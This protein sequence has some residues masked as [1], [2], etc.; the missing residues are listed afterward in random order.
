MTFQLDLVARWFP[1]SFLLVALLVPR[2]AAG[3]QEDA[4]AETA[5]AES[6]IPLSPWLT[7]GP[8]AAPLPAF[9]D[10]P[11]HPFALSD[12]VERWSLPPR[13]VW[14][15]KG[16]GVTWPGGGDVGWVLAE[17]E[18]GMISIAAP[19]EGPA[20]AYLGTYL[21][22]PVW[23]ATAVEIRAAHPVQLALDG[24]L[25]TMTAVEPDGSQRAD[26]TLIPG[27]HRLVVRT[28]RD[29]SLEDPWTLAI[30]LV[31]EADVA[32]PVVTATP[33]RPLHVTDILDAPRIAGA[34]LSPDGELVAV[35]IQGA[36]ASGAPDRWVELRRTRDGELLPTWRGGGGI[37][38]VRWSPDGTRLGY[39]TSGGEGATTLWALDMEVG[40]VTRLAEGLKG[41]G[42]YRWA[43]DG[44]SVVYSYSEEQEADPRKVD[45]LRHPAERE[46]GYRTPSSL[47]RLS[48]DGGTSRRLTA[49]LRG[50]G[51][52]SISPDGARVL[53]LL[54]E[55]D[56]G[57]PP[58]WRTAVW[59]L[60]LATLVATKLIEDSGIH[61]AVYSPDGARI[62][63]MGSPT[64]FGGIGSTVAE[65]A[66]SPAWDN[67]LFLLDRGTGEVAA[68]SRELIPGIAG[69]EWSR[70]DGRIYC[71]CTEGQ[72]RPVHAL[73]PG[74]G[75]WSRVET[76]VEVVGGFDLALGA[77]VAIAFGTGATTPSR[78]TLV[79]P[80]RG[81]A[82]LL[83][84]PGAE[85]YLDVV[86]GDVVPWTC[87]LDGGKELDGRIY[88]PPHFEPDQT[89]PAIVYYYGGV[90]PVTRGFGGR[91]PLN[92][93]AGQGYVV[94]VP[95]P[96]GAVGY[97]Q[98]NSSV[99]VNDWGEVTAAEVIEGTRAFLQAHPFVDGERV[100]C[101]GASYGGFLTQ[102]ILTETDMF[103]AG[104]SHAGI[105][106]LTSYWGVG[107]WGYEYGAVAMTDSYPWSHP[108]LF[109]GR[110]PL[111]DADEINTPLLLL[112]GAEDTN[113][114]RGESD[115]MFVA[116][117]LLGRDVDYVRVLGQDHHIL[118]R[119][120]RIVWSDTILAY[121]ARHLR[122]EPGWW[123]ALYPE[124]ESA[125]QP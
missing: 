108:D 19:A 10:G 11:E 78:L 33:L 96:S 114:P 15:V 30:D 99:H 61:D 48:V 93:W 101:I 70:V 87:T 100:G 76:G 40:E 91:Y 1:C 36:T 57:E 107:L 63:V 37:G 60:E 125:P 74:S 117:T 116:L 92:L 69:I 18:D 9:H 80:R 65:G 45:R 42:D 67:Q 29:P 13:D 39:T 35:S 7:L 75:A 22:A 88:Y 119:D 3:Q 79:D 51:A 102:S 44:T 81:R 97:G 113:V 115:Q 122:D 71:L 27:K 31:L 41:F 17:P 111:F 2:P 98:Q 73:D 121:F 77:R 26:L 85:A 8:V 21:D 54:G 14:P 94:Y 25:Q 16:S 68:V 86:L 5:V 43:P 53:M 90:M 59:E 66:W 24:A 84:D 110:S 64:A 32:S 23:T 105:A 38:R 34:A 106:S 28:V 123:E 62:A 58:F 47:V 46:S 6:R 124:P 4:G 120:R 55:P 20:E 72:Y 50:L 95:Q 12:P 112:H 56:Y 52:W 109:V 118:D 49:G 89:Y 82:R 83:L 103:A 104:V